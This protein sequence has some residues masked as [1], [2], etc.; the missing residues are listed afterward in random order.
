MGESNIYLWKEVFL[1]N[2]RNAAHQPGKERSCKIANFHNRALQGN[3]SQTKNYLSKCV[4]QIIFVR[5]S[6]YFRSRDVKRHSVDVCAT[7]L[8]TFMFYIRESC[9]HV[10][11]ICSYD[12]F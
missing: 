12:P 9:G 1:G 7:S 3:C 2:M 5:K 6:I 10:K 4:F 8:Y 11:N